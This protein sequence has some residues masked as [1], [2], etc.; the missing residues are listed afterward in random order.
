MEKIKQPT[1][2]KVSEDFSRF[3]PLPVREGLFGDPE[4]VKKIISEYTRRYELKRAQEKGYKKALIDIQ[5]EVRKQVDGY[6]SL[7]TKI[8]DFVYE[9]TE[10]PFKEFDFKVTGIRTN[11]YFETQRINILFV[12]DTDFE[13]ERFFS[14]LLDEVEKTILDKENFVAELFY[15]NGRSKKLDETSIEHDYPIFRKIKS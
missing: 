8:S 9:I 12:I 15:I 5:R 4:V 3:P 2:P 13:A 11:F 14:D 7:L 6:I 1:F 10:E